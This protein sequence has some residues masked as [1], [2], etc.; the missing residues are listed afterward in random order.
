MISRSSNVR[1]TVRKRKAICIAVFLVV[2]AVGVNP[3]NASGLDGALK[4]LAAVPF[5]A[6]LL[7]LDGAGLIAYGRL[8][9]RLCPPRSALNTVRLA[10]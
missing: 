8:R 2:V 5:G 10:V 4:S 1:F 7:L 6:V 9:F 3:S